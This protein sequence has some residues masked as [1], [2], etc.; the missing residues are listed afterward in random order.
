MDELIILEMTGRASPDQL[1]ELRRWRE[2]SDENERRYQEVRA[3]WS[4]TGLREEIPADRPAPSADRMVEG[5]PRGASQEKPRF[6][7]WLYGG[8]A[9]AA[10]IVLA[11]G[12]TY[13]GSLVFEPEPP[14]TA[15]FRTGPGELSTAVLDDGTVVRLAPNTTLEATIGEHTR[16]V[17]LEGRAF[18]AVVSDPG[19][20]FQ[21]R[22]P[23]GEVQVIGTRFEVDSEGDRLRLLVLDGRVKLA[24]G[25][26]EA[27]LGAGEQGESVE[28]APPTV[29]RVEVPEA[30]LGWMGAWVAF[31]STP[32]RQVVRELE[33]RLGIPVE[34]ADPEIEDRTISGWFA[35]EDR[36]RMLEL[37]CRVADVR[38]TRTE[39]VIRMEKSE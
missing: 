22:T 30:L 34:I 27:E 4:L 14:V 26:R 9:A 16:D 28:G 13:M 38:C 7:R 32:L 37:I 24:A 20:T 5:S 21:V 3:I 1:E 25:G 11:L 36:D 6:R 18:L 23:R 17:W 35:E 39:D 2:I 15:E 29:T 8:M 31:E 33:V 12:I 19:R 10:V